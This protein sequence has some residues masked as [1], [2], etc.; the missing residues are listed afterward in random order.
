[1]YPFV[2]VIL[3]FGCAESSP[4]AQGR[5]IYRRTQ[6]GNHYHQ[7][8]RQSNEIEPHQAQKALKDVESTIQEVQR[9]LALDPTLPRLTR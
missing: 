1:M 3:L 2:L 8:S 4:V 9:L 6:D 5:R 7:I